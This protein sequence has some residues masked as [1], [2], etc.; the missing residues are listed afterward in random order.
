MTHLERLQRRLAY[1][2]L[3]QRDQP[4]GVHPAM[5]R[6]EGFEADA[7]RWALEELEIWRAVPAEIADWLGRCVPDEAE[8]RTPVEQ[9]L[10]EAAEGVAEIDWRSL[11][12]AAKRN[13]EGGAPS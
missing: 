5:L 4:P 9:T 3:R 12:V 6:N 10:L 13:R 2:E 8:E 7:L 1:L 11:V